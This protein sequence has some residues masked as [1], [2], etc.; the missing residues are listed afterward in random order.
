[1]ATDYFRSLKQQTETRF[2]INNPTEKEVHLS[3]AEGAVSCTTNPAYCSK[4]LQSEPEYITGVIDRVLMDIPDIED[5]AAEAY[6]RAGKRI[7]DM[8]L[9]LY[10]KSGG[11]EGFVTMQ[12]D[13]RKDE[14]TRSVVEAVFTNRKLGKNFMAKI[15]VIA[16]GIEAIETCV[17]ENIPICATEVFAISQAVYM[18]ERYEAACRRTG[19]TP[20]F[21]ITHISGIFDEYLGKTAEREGIDIAP[22]LL[23]IAGLSIARREYAVL[24]ER[25]FNA[26]LLG[27]GA[28]T[29]DHFTGLVGGNAHITIN[30]ST[31]ADIMESPAVPEHTIGLETPAKVVDELKEKFDDYRKAWEDDGLAIGDYAG[32]GPVQLFRNAFLKGWYQLLAEVASRKHAQAL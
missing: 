30:W 7:M 31:A 2:W 29:N 15:P 10:E 32:Y 1:M 12:D 14:D 3:L 8:F 25:G 22:E 9:P 21:F 27:G 16:G 20:P 4:L 18:C 23:Q 5:A 17:E 11:T 28:R 19:N 24:K 13:P 6:R 26:V